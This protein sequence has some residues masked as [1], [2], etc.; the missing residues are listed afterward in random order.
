MAVE[1]LGKAISQNITSMIPRLRTNLTEQIQS[2]WEGA[3]FVE[4]KDGVVVTLLDVTR[5]IPWTANESRKTG[6]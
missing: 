6:T 5:L 2:E 1:V 3:T 4:T